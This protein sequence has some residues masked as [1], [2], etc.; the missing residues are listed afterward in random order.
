VK[1][2]TQK[3]T[4]QKLEYIH[5]NPVQAKIVFNPIDYVFS[6]ATAYAGREMKCPLEIDL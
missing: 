3:F 6:S 1:L 2:V 4:L 5:L